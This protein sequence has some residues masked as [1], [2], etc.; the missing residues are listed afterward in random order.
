MTPPEL[1]ET[2]LAIAESVLPDNDVPL[3]VSEAIVELPLEISSGMA[4]GRLQ[5]FARPPHSR[6]KT[7]FLPEVHQSRLRIGLSETLIAGGQG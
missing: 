1:A 2:L 4:D 7:G 5:F 3:V 6:W